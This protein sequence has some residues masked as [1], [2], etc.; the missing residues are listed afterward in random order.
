MRVKVFKKDAMEE[1]QGVNK[2]N[3]ILSGDS[4]SI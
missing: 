3:Q 4:K 1:P 2:P